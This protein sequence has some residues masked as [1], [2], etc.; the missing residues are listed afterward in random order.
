[1]GEKPQRPQPIVDADQ[2]HALL[3]QGAAVIHG[4]VAVADAQGA[5]V[6]PDHHRPGV[7]RFGPGPDVQVQAVLAA[8]QL[9][10]A[11]DAVDDGLPAGRS[12]GGGVPRLLPGS[13][14]SRRLPAQVPHRR[15]RVG[16]AAKHP[17]AVLGFAAHRPVGSGRQIGFSGGNI[18]GFGG[19]RRC[20]V[21]GAF[22]AAAD[23]RKRCPTKKPNRQIQQASGNDHLFPHGQGAP[24]AKFNPVPHHQ[25]PPRARRKA[26][27]NHKKPAK[28]MMLLLSA[29][30]A[31]MPP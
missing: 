4:Q 30:A 19:G 5:A 24:S 3:G 26:R 14:A 25:A 16:D 28:P 7:S 8:L 15:R 12:E 10:A 21:L 2:H 20:P 23:E 27:R 11:V 6:N 22:R 29:V 18:G 31:K 13:R 1:M 17:H 9:A